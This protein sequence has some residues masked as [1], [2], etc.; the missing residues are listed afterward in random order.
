MSPA[1]LVTLGGSPTRSDRRYAAVMRYLG[2]LL[3]LFLAIPVSAQESPP[4]GSDRGA[5]VAKPMPADPAGRPEL[6]Y[7]SDGIDDVGIAQL[8]EA[9]PNV[10]IIVVH[11]RE[12]AMEHAKDVHGADASLANPEFIAAAPNLVWVHWGSAGI[13]RLLAN[14]PLMETDRIVLTNSR[15]V[16]GPVIADHAM[17]MLLMLTRNM[18]VHERNQAAGRWG[19]RDARAGMAL[20]GRTMLVVGLGGIGS[21]IAQR[22]HGF[23]MRV[24]GTRRSDAPSPDYLERVGKPGDLL[25]MLPQA[26]VVA[27][28]VPLTHETRGMFNEKAFAAMKPGSFLINV[29][30]GQIVETDHLVAALESG[31]LAGA[32]LDVTDPE[33]LPPGHKLWAMPNVIITPHCSGVAELSDERWW[34]LFAENVRRFGAGEPLLNT[35]DKQAGY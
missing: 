6:L 19:G 5:R 17:A 7:L 29:A 30:R 22:A 11:S 24:I 18:R 33:P 1:H 4:V 10:R 9:A 27:I 3:S 12:E 14:R 26:D 32:C 31:R 28:A 20:E 2:L 21:E 16:S 13:E 35:V 15:A 8:K 25:E 34:A 23:G